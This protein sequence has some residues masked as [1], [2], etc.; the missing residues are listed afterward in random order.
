MK[1]NRISIHATS[2]LIWQTKPR[3]TLS[4]QSSVHSVKPNRVSIC[5]PCNL[6]FNL[7]NQTSITTLSNSNFHYSCFGETKNSQPMQPMVRRSRMTRM[8]HALRSVG[9]GFSVTWNRSDCID[10]LDPDPR[11]HGLTMTRRACIS[12]SQLQQPSLFVPFTS[13]VNPFLSLPPS[14]PLSLSH[15][16][17]P[18]H[19]LD[20]H[21]A[22][23]TS[24]RRNIYISIYIYIYIYIY[25]SIYIYIYRSRLIQ[26]A[27]YSK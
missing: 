7:S 11:N 5:K 16:T 8:L 14:P 27:L 23:P 9:S 15:L 20:H 25:I 13:S 17:D 22:R 2:F 26:R 3:F 6:G 19:N 1:S 12:A 18:H 10:R 4:N 24:S 21:Y